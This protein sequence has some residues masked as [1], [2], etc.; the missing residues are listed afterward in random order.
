MQQQHN[1]KINLKSFILAK[2]FNI[3]L[4][5]AFTKPKLELNVK[6]FRLL[7]ILSIF[8]LFDRPSTHCCSSGSMAHVKLRPLL[9]LG[10]NLKV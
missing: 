10:V 7:I 6:K 9:L 1:T 2:Y 3:F 8:L 4:I 5:N